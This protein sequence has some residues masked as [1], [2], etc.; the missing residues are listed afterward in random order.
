[1]VIATSR[2]TRFLA[3]LFGGVLWGQDSSMRY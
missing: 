1:M 2:L 3:F